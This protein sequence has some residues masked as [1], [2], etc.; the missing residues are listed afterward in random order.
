MPPPSVIQAPRATVPDVRGKSQAQARAALQYAGFTYSDGGAIDSELPAGMIAGSSPSG[1]SWVSRGSSVT[2]YSS[3]GAP[4]VE[5]DAG[6][7]TEGGTGAPS[8]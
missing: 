7:T 4:K 2:V 5:P 8:G 1:G 3:N 6:D